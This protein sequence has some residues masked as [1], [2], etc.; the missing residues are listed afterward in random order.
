MFKTLTFFHVHKDCRLPDSAQLEQALSRFG[1]EPTAPT[2]KR[3]AGWSPPRGHEHGALAENIGGQY[4]FELTVE[5]RKVPPAA[6]KRELQARIEALQA[7]GAKPLRG[8]AK[9]A[10]KEQIEAELLP[11]AFARRG[12]IRA[13][14]DPRARALY[15]GSGSAGAVEALL[16]ELQTALEAELGA[17]LR[18]ELP[19]LETGVSQ[20]LAQWLRGGQA[21]EFALEQECILRANDDSGA[22]VRF[23]HH[24]LDQ[25]A[26]L[27]H[28]DE[29]KLPV[30]VALN[31]EGRVSFVLDE[32]LRLKKLKLMGVS[33]AGETEGAETTGAGA[34][35][36]Q[37]AADDFD[38]DVALFT[39]EIAQMLPRLLQALGARRAD[40]GGRKGPSEATE[41]VAEEAASGRAAQAAEA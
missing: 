21:G 41:E 11:R 12:S 24:L 17:G 13:W 9:R 2:A 7:Q 3:S 14:L 30:Q 8:K 20:T 37:S 16:E 32:A 22:S 4:L 5:T 6:L 26:V 1:F 18:L 34:E 27:Q 23:A 38:G 40:E 39:G 28:V 19:Q 36:V 35:G 25:P 29:G 15:V 10:L 31:W 33:S